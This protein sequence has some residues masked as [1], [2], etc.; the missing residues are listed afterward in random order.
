[1]SEPL[2]D[3]DFISF[4]GK[5]RK[6]IRKIVAKNALTVAII[7][8]CNDIIKIYQKSDYSGMVLK[9]IYHSKHSRSLIEYFKQCGVAEESDDYLPIDF[10]LKPG[11][12]IFGFINNDYKKI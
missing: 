11:S 12:Y 10:Q 7:I 3:R 9:R 6:T 8:I 1:M 4:L 2:M 5:I